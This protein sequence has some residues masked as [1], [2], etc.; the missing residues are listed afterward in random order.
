MVVSCHGVLIYYAFP[1]VEYCVNTLALQ[2][3]Q[4]SNI[5]PIHFHAIINFNMFKMYIK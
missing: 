2:R 1:D 3:F 4:L 5:P